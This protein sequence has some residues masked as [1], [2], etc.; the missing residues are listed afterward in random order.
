M[1]ADGSSR[2]VSP[3]GLRQ[4]FLSLQLVRRDPVWRVSGK[5][6][7]ANQ[8]GSF[9]KRGSLA[10]M[11][12]E[13]SWGGDVGAALVSSDGSSSNSSA[14][15]A[16]NGAGFLWPRMWI[17]DACPLDSVMGDDRG[18]DE[19]GSMESVGGDYM[20]AISVSSQKR[21]VYYKVNAQNIPAVG[22]HLSSHVRGPVAAQLFSS[23][24]HP[25]PLLPPPTVPL[26]SIRIK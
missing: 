10:G 16:G 14:S 2:I 5:V 13:F 4:L 20:N 18:G 12:S 23:V 1:A 26:V 8:S 17:G 22:G 9:E 6:I 11:N 24:E 19:E 25:L 21:Y 7:V 3:E 15:N